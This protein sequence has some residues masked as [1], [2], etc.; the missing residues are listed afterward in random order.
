VSVRWE[1]SPRR[2]RRNLLLL[3]GLLPSLVALAVAG[4]LLLMLARQE[5]GVAATQRGAHDAAR[6]HFAG[7]RW[8]GTVEHWV[9]PFNEGVATFRAGDHADA[10]ADFQAALPDVPP[11]QECLVRHNIAVT[12]EV[13]GDAAGRDR[14]MDDY[15]AGREALARGRCLERA[16]GEA[17]SSAALDARLEQKIEQLLA[18]LEREEEAALTPGE[19][20][21]QER[22]EEREQRARE[23]EQR[24]RDRDAGNP[25]DDGGYGW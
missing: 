21:R 6:G 16:A 11:E 1:P 3:A 22:L 15:R 12:R 14:A 4:A 8:F 25:E 24:A 18:Q 7:N 13:L 2:R 5:A 9:A 19:R 17:P 10:L 20:S 23:R